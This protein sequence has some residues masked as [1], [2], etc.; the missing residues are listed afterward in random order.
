MRPFAAD[1]AHVGDE[2]L[3]SAELSAREPNNCGCKN[4]RTLVEQVLCVAPLR[5]HAADPVLA[6]QRMTFE[7]EARLDRPD[8]VNAVV[9]NRADEERL[10]GR[11]DALVPAKRDTVG[12]KWL[13]AVGYQPRDKR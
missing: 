9:G 1:L 2:I 4:R 3:N 10:R 11:P 6:G 13:P 8:E 12:V 7:E 5:F